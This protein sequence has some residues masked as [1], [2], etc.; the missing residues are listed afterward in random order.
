MEDRE[1]SWTYGRPKRGLCSHL[2]YLNFFI[3]L[4]MS[5]LS[6]IWL[7]ISHSCI[8]VSSLLMTVLMRM[9]LHGNCGQARRMPRCEL[10]A[11]GRI[12]DVRGN[13]SAHAN[14]DAAQTSIKPGESFIIMVCVFIG[15]AY[16][17][18]LHWGLQPCK[19]GLHAIYYAKTEYETLSISETFIWGEKCVRA[20]SQINESRD[21]LMGK[22]QR[23]T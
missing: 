12:A 3:F 22:L 2:T 10:C 20:F 21:D 1:K 4:I 14:K 7:S 11:L 6:S 23:P 17:Q 8:T 19:L 5:S 15:P 13:L 16:L 9:G 18:S